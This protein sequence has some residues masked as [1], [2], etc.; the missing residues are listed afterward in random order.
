MDVLGELEAAAAF[1][2][3]ERHLC[4]YWIEGWVEARKI[5]NVMLKRR[6]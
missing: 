5:L 1:N 4:A 3:S 6:Q 2:T